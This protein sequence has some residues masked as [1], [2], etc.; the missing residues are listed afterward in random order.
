MRVHTRKGLQ[1]KQIDWGNETIRLGSGT[2]KTRIPAEPVAVP[3]P[4]T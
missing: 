2:E 4:A 1:R 3:D